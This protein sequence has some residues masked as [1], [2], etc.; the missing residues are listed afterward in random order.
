[1]FRANR[2]R[3]NRGSVQAAV[4]KSSPRSRRAHKHTLSLNG[5]RN[6]RVGNNR[7]YE[8]PPVLVRGVSGGAPS[9]AGR[10]S[11]N[12]RRYDVAI[13][14]P[15][16]EMRLPSLPSFRLGWHLLSGLMAVALLG[17]LYYL[18][19]APMFRVQAVELRGLQHLSQADVNTVIG[20]SGEP[21]FTVNPQETQAD[22]QTAFPEMSAIT[23][24]VRLP[25][26]V[27]I[28]IAER[29]PVL[30]WKKEGQ[31]LWIDAN[32][33]SF[34]PRGDAGPSVTVEGDLPVL[35]STEVNTEGKAPAPRL[36]PQTVSGILT[37]GVQAPKKARLL[38]D[39]EHGLG[40]KDKRGWQVYFGTTGMDPQTLALKLNIYAA[41][42]QHLVK[43]DV[44]P[45]LISV[46]Y[47]HAPYYRVE[48]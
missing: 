45:N 22:L 7:A 21:V 30:A 40:W 46:E 41:L 9:P 26:S 39:S 36:D 13:G 34:P 17:G 20:L 3:G 4:N 12:K 32:G 43:N 33:V 14:I 37:L 42:V 28:S 15:G 5:R 23:V 48:Q 6:N 25:A 24:E 8:Q 44:R 10:R 1:M 31:E 27:I 11:K 2:S 47:V 35:E 29:T 38:Y 18:W 16:A 19:T